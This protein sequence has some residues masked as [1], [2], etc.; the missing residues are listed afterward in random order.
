[1]RY[2]RLRTTTVGLQQGAVRPFAVVIP[3]DSV[4]R[5]PDGLPNADG[6]VEAEWDGQ[7]IQL[8]A[9]DLADRGE[10][11]RTMSAGQAAK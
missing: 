11:I 9:V 7:I 2:Y 1:M 5:V 3:A 6:F 4:L 8:F 10:R